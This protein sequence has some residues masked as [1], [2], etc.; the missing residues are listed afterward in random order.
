[1]TTREMRR[2]VRQR[3]RE[4]RALEAALANRPVPQRLRRIW[5]QQLHGCRMNRQ[6]WI[7]F[8]E[9]RAA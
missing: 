4:I 8:L 9:K 1:M 2:L 6:A 5:L 7:D 3:E